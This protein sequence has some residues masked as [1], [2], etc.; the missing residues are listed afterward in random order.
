MPYRYWSDL[1]APD[2]TP[3]LAG[4]VALLPVGATEQHGPHLPLNTDTLLATEMAELSAAA[5]NSADVLILPTIAV[6][7]SDEHIHFPGTLTLDGPTLLSVLEQIGASVARAG[8]K[9]LVCINAH[10]GNVPALQMLVRSL[11]IQHDILAVTAGWIGMGFPE[12]TVSPREQAEGIHGGLVETAAMLH[13]RPDLVDM[14]Q[15]QHFV[16]ASAAVA[17]SNSVLRMM[18][19]VTTGWCAEDL[20]PAGAAGDAASATAALG[21][22]LVAH[23]AARFGTLLDEVAAHPLP[24][25]AA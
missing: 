1:R 12:G 18:G 13:F 25:S 19:S 15:A 6:A 7:K 17:Q 23:S 22:Q 3:A 10:G 21:A 14:T 11:R 16:P 4:A 2:F 8:I 24:G 5:A 20:H 9:R